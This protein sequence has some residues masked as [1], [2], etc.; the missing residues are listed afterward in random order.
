M[1]IAQLLHKKMLIKEKERKRMTKF[2]F[3]LP[4]SNVGEFKLP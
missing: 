4:L 1:S 2:L 3:S